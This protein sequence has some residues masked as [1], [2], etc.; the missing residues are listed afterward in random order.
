MSLSMSLSLL[1]PSLQDRL[2]Q[3]SKAYSLEKVTFVAQEIAQQD[4]KLADTIMQLAKNFD[5]AKIKTH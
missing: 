1:E 4:K 2:R 3:A 5:F